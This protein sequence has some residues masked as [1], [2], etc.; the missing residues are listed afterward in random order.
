IIME[1][2]LL[3]QDLT[4]AEFRDQEEIVENLE[5]LKENLMVDFPEENMGEEALGKQD[6]SDR[7]GLEQ[8]LLKSEASE[9][10]KE[11]SDGEVLQS[12]NAQ[13]LMEEEQQEKEEKNREPVIFTSDNSYFSDALFI[14]DSRTEGLREYGNL[15]QATV[16]A[17]SG[18][19]IYRLWKATFTID[20][21]KQTLEQILTEKKFGKVY[22]MLGINELGYD[23]DQTINKYREALSRIEEAQPEA[24][25][26]LMANLHVTDEK[27]K[28]SDIYNNTNIN[29][30]NQRLE[31]LAKEKGYMYLDVNPVFDDENGNL[32]KKYTVDQAHILGIYYTDWGNWILEHCV[33]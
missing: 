8:D 15:G 9:T 27:A 13:Q 21:K 26:F 31:E 7:E 6:A 30:M 19:S 20:N 28:N 24:F 29:Q 32:S 11:I 33:K 5:L 16:L 14:G 1:E 25:I 23:R 17:D 2:K 22:L 18:M 10:G 4:L 12:E 3:E